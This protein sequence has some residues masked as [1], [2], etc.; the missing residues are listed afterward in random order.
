MAQLKFYIFGQTYSR[1][2]LED[3]LKEDKDLPKEFKRTRGPLSKFEDLA[4]LYIPKFEM[5]NGSETI[6]KRLPLDEW[7]KDT[8]LA[9][10]RLTATFNKK[11]AKHQYLALGTFLQNPQVSQQFTL[12][13]WLKKNED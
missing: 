4:I 12:E 1:R 7:R 10:V 9:L 2:E 3:L 8:L 11:S 6:N 13:N 5:R